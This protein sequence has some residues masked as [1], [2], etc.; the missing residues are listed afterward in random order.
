MITPAPVATTRACT[1]KPRGGADRALI[2]EAERRQRRAG[3]DAELRLDQID[4]RHL[5]GDRVLDLDARVALDEEVLAGLGE[6]QEL[7]GAGVHVLRG[8]R[9]LERIGEDA[10][11]QRLPE[12]RRGRDLDHLLVAQLHR[13]VALVEVDDVAVRV[14]QDLHFDVARAQ[15]RLLDEERAVAERRLGLAP[16]ALEGL[17]HLLRIAARDACRAHR[18]RPPPSAS[19]GSRAAPPP[20]AA[21]AGDRT[22]S[23]AAGHDRDAD[24]LRER[25]SATLSPNRASA[26][27]ARP[28]EGDAG[29]RAALRRRPRSP[30]GSRSPGGR[31]RSRPSGATA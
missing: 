14:A 3:G 6:H 31:S 5:L 27:G 18:R 17:G 4:A 22:A 29:G 1:A 12:A 16:A 13:A 21:S 10:L 7:D 15:E 2:A 11:A 8:A 25:A 9:E 20:A 19:P 23:G 30:R 24:R 28:D 26:A